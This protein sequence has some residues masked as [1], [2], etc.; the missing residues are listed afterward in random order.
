M[1]T[2]DIDPDQIIADAEQEAAE[3]EKLVDTLEEA[4]KSGDDSV[5][6][7]QVEKARGLLSF[8][9]LRKEAATRKAAA[10]KEAARVEACEALKADIT[11]QVKGDGDRFSKQLK[12][13]VDG[14]RE[15]YEAAEARN[16][17]VREFRRRAGNLGIPEQKHMGPAAATHGGVRLAANGGPGLTA[18]V[19]VGRRRVD[20]IDINIFVNRALNMLARENKYKHLDFVDAGDDLFGDLARVDAEAP[21]ST[22]KYFY[23]GPNGGVFAKDDPF[24]PEEIKRNQLTVITKAEAFSE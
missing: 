11:T 4:V 2:T 21:E 10:A 24:T 14:L 12:T 6:F 7:E 5:T 18:G 3:A 13:A 9:R 1:S 20:V 19:I 16:E 15:L 17:N 23:R 8:V 22:A